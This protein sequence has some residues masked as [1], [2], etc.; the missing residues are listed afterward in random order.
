[1]TETPEHRAQRR[2]KAEID[3]FEADKQAQGQAQLDWWWQTKLDLEAEH[4]A[5]MRRLNEFGLKIY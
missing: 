5:M 1:M 3:E 4:R 2:W